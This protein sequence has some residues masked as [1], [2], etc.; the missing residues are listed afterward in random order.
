[1][2]RKREKNKK[3][4]QDAFPSEIF[5]VPD[6]DP[7]PEDNLIRQQNLSNLLA[8]IKKLKPQYQKIN[9]LRYFEEHSIL[10]I[11]ESLNEPVNNI[12]VKLFRAR[13]TLAEIINSH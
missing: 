5:Q 11:S 13:K 4:L 12:K 3:Q 10:E 6:N 1:M 8:D 2:Y 7:T 9:H